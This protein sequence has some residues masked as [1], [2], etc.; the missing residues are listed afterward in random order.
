MPGC[1]CNFI[2][3]KVALFIALFRHLHA[4]SCTILQRLQ[5]Y[6]HLSIGISYL[7]NFNSDRIADNLSRPENIR[8]LRETQCANLTSPKLALAD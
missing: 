8:L 4:Q 5:L 1:D 6:A 3:Q 7:C 2:S